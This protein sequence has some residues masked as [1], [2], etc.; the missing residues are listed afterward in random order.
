MSAIVTDEPEIM[1][2]TETE[3]FLDS[4]V[5]MTYREFDEA[6]ECARQSGLQIGMEIGRINA[7]FEGN[8][9]KSDAVIKATDSFQEH[10]RPVA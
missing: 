4:T 6:C 9:I 1:T 8:R 2:A 7:E 10:L 3:K 5:T